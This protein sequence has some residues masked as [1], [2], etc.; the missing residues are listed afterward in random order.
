VN[1]TTGGT[2]KVADLTLAEVKTLDAGSRFDPKFKGERV[3]TL[4]EVLEVSKGK[5]RVMIDLKEAGEEYAKRIA[6]EVRD[7]GEPKRTIMGVRSV[8][9]ARQFGKLP[10]ARQIGLVP[11]AAD[12]EPFAKA[13]V[14]SSGCGR[15]G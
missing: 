4:R 10:E 12:I 9:H 1:R 6:A 5:I 14:R 3:P 15:S 7:H 11:T 8:E 2:G 13:G